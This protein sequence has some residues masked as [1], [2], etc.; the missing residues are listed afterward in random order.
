MKWE[1]LTRLVISTA[2]IVSM[3]MPATDSVAGIDDVYMTGGGGGGGGGA[4]GAGGGFG[5]GGG[6]GGYIGQELLSDIKGGNGGGYGGYESGKDGFSGGYLGGGNKGRGGAGGNSATLMDYTAL[7]GDSGG[8]GDGDVDSTRSD[9]SGGGGIGGKGGDVTVTLT[10]LSGDIS[11]PG[12]LQLTGGG[13]GGGANKGADGGN[14]GGVTLSAATN[15]SI[16]VSNLALIGGM[17]G[18]GGLDDGGGQ[19]GGQGGD[20]GS[21]TLAANGSVTVDRS[22]TMTSGKNGTQGENDGGA[23][24]IG[25]AVTFI[26]KTLKAASVISLTKQD[27]ALNVNVGTLDITQ[28]DT[29]LTL[30]GTTTW[31]GNASTGVLFD[32]IELGNT[33]NLTVSAGGAFS[34]NTLNVHGAANYTGDLNAANRNL[35]FFV[36]AGTVSGAVLLSTSTADITD[37]KV[38]IVVEDTSSPLKAGDHLVLIDAASLSG[39]PSNNHATAPGM[40]GVSLA[41][42][43]ELSTTGTQ[44][45]ATIPSQ[46]TDPASGSDPVPGSVNPQ[47]EALPEAF[48]GGLGLV[49]Q[50]VDLAAGQGM[51]AMWHE[52]AHGKGKGYTAFAVLSG[53]S[54]KYKTGSHVD[55]DSHNVMTGITGDMQ[56]ASGNLTLGAFFTYGRGDYDT[57]NSFSNAA[58]VHGSGDSDYVGVGMLG[59]LDFNATKTGHPYAEGSFQAGRVKTDFHSG[60]LTDL[61]GVGARYNARSTYYG[62]HLA[63]GYVWNVTEKSEFDAYVK[64]LYAR[65]NSNKVTLNTGDPIRFNAIESHRLRLGGR[66]SGTAAKVN[67]YVGLAWEHEFDGRAKATTYDRPIVAPKLKG[68]TGIAELGLVMKPS[69]STPLTIDLGIQGYTGRREGASGSIRVEYKF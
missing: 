5:G 30:E 64:Y 6:A 48:L 24:G 11:V 58:S 65:R 69:A 13:G 53:G 29:L 59:R 37:S 49:N 57:H 47:T 40:Q 66:Y 3:W 34:F 15:R 14:G 16:T 55:V 21:V 35:N 56:L 50:G 43:F 25:G 32:T 68:N 7:A 46:G 2:S 20:G 63:T 60:D 52:I 42:E 45:L 44:L 62:L 17:G 9:G 10:P 61:Q 36:A 22:F 12:K 39:S 41:Y 26:A 19:G 1:L 38:G 4:S 33:R 8:P 28:N 23:G 31:D 18:G 54:S 51:D 27:G 67:P